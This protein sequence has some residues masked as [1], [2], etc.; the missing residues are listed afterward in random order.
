M[1]EGAPRHVLL[2][3]VRT[4]THVVH[5][6]SYLRHVLDLDQSPVEVRVLPTGSL[7]AEGPLT[8][9]AVRALLPEDTRLTTLPGT[10]ADVPRAPATTTLLCIG[11]PAVRAWSSFTAAHRGR[12]PRVV[13]V[14]EGLGSY[15]TWRT[16]RSAYRREG[17]GELRSTVRAAAV[18]TGA[19]LLP[20]ERWSLHREGPGGWVV[21]ER[22]AAEFRRRLAGPPAPPDQV[23]YLAQPW[24]AL[25]V[26]TPAA[27]RAHLESLRRVTADAGLALVVKPHPWQGPEVHRGLELLVGGPAELERPVV[28]SALVVGATST[29]LLNLAAVHGTPVARLRLPELDGLD[30]ALSPRQRSLLDAHL[31]AGV[32]VD[33]L[34]LLRR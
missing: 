26:L 28:G 11:A 15:G 12:R 8:T 7:L 22:V 32:P 4:R 1:S 21:D 5:A 23:V 19:R 27:Y 6:S 16:R 18:A 34:E 2:S 31:P 20:D 33:R 10:A 29:A 30:R 3:G 17:G 24:T 14:D 9:D 25:G 13:V